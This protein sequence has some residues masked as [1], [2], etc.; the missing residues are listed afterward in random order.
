MNETNDMQQQQNEQMVPHNPEVVQ[1]EKEFDRETR[2]TI[3]ES[4]KNR[5]KKERIKAEEAAKDAERVKKELDEL[6]K[7]FES[8]KA[9]SNESAEY[10][11][12]QNKV[13][14]AVQQ[15][16]DPSELPAIIDEYMKLQKFDQQ[17]VEAQEK[18]PELKALMQDPA[19]VQKISKAEYDSFAYL[20]NPAAVFKH[21]QKNDQDRMVL[22]AAEQ[23]YV[24][25]DG[26][27]QYFT[28]LNNLSAKL[29]DTAV[30]PHPPNFKP[31]ASLTDIGE[32]DSF[33]SESYIKSRYGRS[34][35]S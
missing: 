23:A 13:E 29:N 17:M 7:K 19:S 1:Q 33:D 10:V 2:D 31:S 15:G 30:Y 9:T 32:S 3:E 11:M 14:Q 28:F 22:K 35:K 26:G 34:G 25:G 5:L 20:K 18:D 12:T 6:K 4:F 21:L 8:G 24:N 27:V 16:I